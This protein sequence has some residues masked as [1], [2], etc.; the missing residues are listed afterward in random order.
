MGCMNEMVWRYQL[1][2][3]YMG[4]LAHRDLTEIIF[5]INKTPQPTI[6]WAYSWDV[7]ESKLRTLS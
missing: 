1:M 5:K 3:D 2:I 7:A 4:R 6:G